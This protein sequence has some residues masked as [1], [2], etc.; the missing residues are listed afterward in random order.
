VAF[1]ESLR[2]LLRGRIRPEGRLVENLRQIKSPREAG[3]IKQ[4]AAFAWEALRRAL[5]LR[6]GI[7]ES[8]LAGRIEFE[9]R[10][11]GTR[12]AFETIVAFGANASQPHYRPAGRRLRGNDTVLIDFGVRWNGYCCDMTRCY[13]VGSVAHAYRK[14]Y[15]TVLRAH[16]QAVSML[17]PGVSVKEIDDKVRRLI[18]DSGLPPYGHGLGH[19]LGLEIHERPVISSKADTQLEAGQIVTIEP[20]VYVPGRFGIRIEDDYLIASRGCRLLSAGTGRLAAQ[21]LVVLKVR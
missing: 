13:A 7:T 2:K 3:L 16:K 20:G 6:R 12:P 19:G 14:A 10:R 9:M 5:V 17:R 1:Y 11:L 18:A 15:D 8:E 21:S 4:A